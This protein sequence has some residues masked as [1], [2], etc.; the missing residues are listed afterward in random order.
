VNTKVRDVLRKGKELVT[1]GWFKGHVG[2]DGP[3][4][5]DHTGDDTCLFL[6]V[7]FHQPNRH[8]LHLEEAINILYAALPVEFQNENGGQD[9][10]LYNNN[11]N[12]TKQDVIAVFDRALLN[13]APVETVEELEEELVTC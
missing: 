12:T 2:N 3:S 5:N 7:S 6:S 13:E 9:L 8:W 1:Q 11:I 10:V 4:Y